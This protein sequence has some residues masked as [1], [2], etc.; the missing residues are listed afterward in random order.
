MHLIL[1]IVDSLKVGYTAVSNSDS[2]SLFI[3]LTYLVC[4]IIGGFI[5]FFLKHWKTKVEINKLNSESIKNIGDY[6][7]KKLKLKRDIDTKRETFRNNGE[8]ISIMIDEVNTYLRKREEVKLI[9]SRENLNHFYFN[10]YHNSFIDY[11]EEFMY[12]YKKPKSGIYNIIEDDSIP[13]LDT[14]IDFLEIVNLP[15]ILEVS[16]SHKIT[17]EENNFNKLK[18]LKSRRIK[19]R[20]KKIVKQYSI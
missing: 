15:I 17:I 10:E 4:L 6:E 8:T 1:P 13:Y 18:R 16:N 5:G 7:E 2:I 11:L 14:T 20:V 9:N 3:K 19:K 12:M